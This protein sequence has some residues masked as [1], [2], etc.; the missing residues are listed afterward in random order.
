[1]GFFDDFHLLAKLQPVW[2][3]L[4]PLPLPLPPLFPW[5][6]QWVPSPSPPEQ[7][8]PPLSPPGLPPPPPPELPPLP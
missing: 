7:A 2:D 4:P 1:M 8:P 6:P 3:S 5:P